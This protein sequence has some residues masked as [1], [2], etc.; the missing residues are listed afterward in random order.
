MTTEFTIIHFLAL[1]FFL[2]LFFKI[3]GAV[4]F[5][6]LSYILGNKLAALLQDTAPPPS[7]RR[8]GIADQLQK[9]T[10]PPLQAR[11][12]RHSPIYDE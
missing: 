4:L 8:P 1:F 3:I 11:R 6:L 2:I 12:P 7:E 10:P 9:T 5:W